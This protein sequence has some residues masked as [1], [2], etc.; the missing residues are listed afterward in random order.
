MKTEMVLIRHGETGHNANRI[1][2]GWSESQLNERGFL[3]VQATAKALQNEVFDEIWYSDLDRT[4]RTMQEIAV[5][6]PGVPMYPC[7][8]LREWH[9]GFL[10]GYSHD[11]IQEKYPE[12]ETMFFTESVDLPI[13][14]GERRSEFQ[15][16]VNRVF[17]ELAERCMGKKILVVT[18]GGVL[19]RFYYRLTGKS[20]R[21]IPEVANAARSRAV[22]D[23]E[24]KEWTILEWGVPCDL[25]T[26]SADPSAPAL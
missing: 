19:T 3:Q 2:Q 8:G 1:I 18:H 24:S 7:E 9:L 14:G 22:Y 25:G 21:D 12:Y 17:D 10:E 26:I 20:Y 16:R 11:E 6:H 15:S 23:S 4:F 5:Y 13:S